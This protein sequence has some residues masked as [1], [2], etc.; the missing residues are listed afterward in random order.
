MLLMTVC[1][2]SLQACQSLEPNYLPRL[3]FAIVQ[4]RHQTRLIA[5]DRNF[6]GKSGNIMP[7]TVVDTMICH[8]AEFDFYLCSHAGIH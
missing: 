7:G 2:L 4:K 3:T 5:A 8:P 6:D 1:S